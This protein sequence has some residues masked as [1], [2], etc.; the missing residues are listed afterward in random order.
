MC[1]LVA[2]LVLESELTSDLSKIV[3]LRSIDSSINFYVTE[4]RIGLL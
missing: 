2:L 1:K 3:I 4:G